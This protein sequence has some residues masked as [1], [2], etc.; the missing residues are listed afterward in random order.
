MSLHQMVCNKPRPC[1]KCT[2]SIE[3]LSGDKFHI[4]WEYQIDYVE[5]RMNVLPNSKI[6]IEKHF[7]TLT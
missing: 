6:M 1:Y 4:G 3:L 2:E 7:K 5:K